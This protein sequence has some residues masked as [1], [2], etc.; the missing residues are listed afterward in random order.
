MLPKVGNAIGE[1]Q[2]GPRSVSCTLKVTLENLSVFDSELISS[3]V[4]K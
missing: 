1:T 4:I 3:P 2:S